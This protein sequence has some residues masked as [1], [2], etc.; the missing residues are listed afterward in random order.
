MEA[1][2]AEEEVIARVALE[3]RVTRGPGARKCI[4]SIVY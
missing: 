4:V 3:E 2:A 1:L